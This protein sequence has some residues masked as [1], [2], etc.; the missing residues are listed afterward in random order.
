[1]K[2]TRREFLKTGTAAAAALM[3]PAAYADKTVQEQA[4][5]RPNIVMILV[6]DMGFSD[7]GPYGSEISTPSL[8]K[9]A[10]G[11]LRFTQFY[12]SPRCC[13]SR[14]S[15]FTGLYSQQAGM[16]LMTAGYGRYP[17]PGSLLSG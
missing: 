5:R 1:M 16:G 14:A 10:K 9:L 3:L 8:D 4:P 2:G 11:G 6:D 15:L 13:P 12:N 7:I 17:Y